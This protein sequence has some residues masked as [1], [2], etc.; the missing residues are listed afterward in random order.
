MLHTVGPHVR[1]A[2]VSKSSSPVVGLI[3][4]VDKTVFSVGKV[5]E[6]AYSSMQ[7]IPGLISHINVN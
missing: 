4:L 3:S 5:E 2:V 7:V 1:V 6:A